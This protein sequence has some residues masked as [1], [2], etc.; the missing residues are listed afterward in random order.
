MNQYPDDLTR[1]YE[2]P[3]EIHYDVDEGTVT[4]GDFHA[5]NQ[6]RQTVA[7][8]AGYLSS[9]MPYTTVTVHDVGTGQTTTYKNGLET[10]P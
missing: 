9:R 6:D 5:G 1:V 10:T 2:M 3:V 8:L 7:T 4:I